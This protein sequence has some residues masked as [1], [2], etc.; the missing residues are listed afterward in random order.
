MRKHLLLLLVSLATLPGCR[1]QGKRSTG[2][3]DGGPAVPAATAALAGRVADRA[4]RPVPEARILAF[5]LA[6]DGAGAPFETATDLDGRFRFARL[7][8]GP[9]RLLVEAAGFPTAEKAPVS[10]PSEDAAVRV[11]GEGRS[12][13]G[14]VTAAG[15]PAAGARVLLAPDSGGPLRETVTRAGG[16]F[17]FGGLGAG[18]YA[19]RATSGDSASAAVRAIEATESPTAAVVK[20]E[21]GAGRAVAGRVIDDAGSPLAEV[22]VRI[23]TDALAAGEDPLPT[24]ATSDAAGNFAALV[25][26]GSYRLS[27][28]RP[29]HILRR[30]PVIDA[31]GAGAPVKAVLEL[32]RGARVFGKVLDPRGGAAAG[33]RVRCLA[34]AI[35]DLTVQTGPLPLAAEAAAM[36][37]GA[38]RALGTTRGTVADHEGRFT[39]DDLIPGRYRVEVAHGGA[40]PLRSDEFML[41]PGERR[42]VGKLAL[43]PGFPVTGRVVD[44][45]GAPIDGAR[46]VVAQAGASPASVGLSTITDS[47][48]LFALALPAGSYRLSANAAGRGT[49]QAA[50][51]VAAGSSPPAV[52]IKLSRADARLEGMIRDDGGRPLARARLAVWPA[53]AVE[54]GATPGASP[55]ASGVADVGGHFTIA[56]L[57]AGEARLQ[58]QHPDYPTSVQAVTAGTYANLTVPF[59]GGVAGE[60]K[61][62]ITGAAIARGRL[63]ATGPGG[64]K[65]TTDVRRD[66]TFRLLRLVPGH[67]RL[68]VVATG[69][70]NAE[71]ELEVP[72]S[73]NLG[74]ASIRDLRVELEGS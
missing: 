31:R 35:E 14:L 45:G 70:R 1:C 13:V 61:A 62:K 40:E 66:G 25:F 52:V 27:A 9:Y 32:V 18:R 64:A 38:G 50:V 56:P 5:P 36:P 15:A 49:A 20:L 63:E 42:D 7:P 73:S 51:D 3:R 53:D 26:P 30:A 67:W 46:V 11:D 8:R 6:S 21:L 24:L 44:E 4:D 60:V 72:A 23:E 19:V 47:G 16:G 69:Y 71:Q 29:G 39:V 12:I 68:T 34:S 74:E 65:A 2:A 37:S 22:P 33:A 17:A 41:A 48:G 57:P 28:S 55:V 54:P 43:R 59:P 10:A 58:I